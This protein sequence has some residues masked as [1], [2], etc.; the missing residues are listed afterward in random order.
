MEIPIKF[1]KQDPGHLDSGPLYWQGIANYTK[2]TRIQERKAI[3]EYSKP[4]TTHGTPPIPKKLAISF[5]T[6]MTNEYQ[7]N[8]SRNS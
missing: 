1:D 5:L 8:R 4:F 2:K 7:C 3:N 6:T